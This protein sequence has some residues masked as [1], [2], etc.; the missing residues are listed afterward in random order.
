MN[1]EEQNLD[2]PQNPQL[3]LGAISRSFLSE[4]DLVELGFEKR[5][6]LGTGYVSISSMRPAKYYYKKGRITINA[7]EFWTW[8]LDGEQRTDI[9]VSN[10]D[11]LRELLQNYG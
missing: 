6:M 4:D 9:A 5:L 11:S 7:T 1:I 3:N 2:N 10:K 8:I